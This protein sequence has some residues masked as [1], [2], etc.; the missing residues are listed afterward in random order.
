M[1]PSNMEF[2]GRSGQNATNTKLKGDS[3]R[4]APS[5]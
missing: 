5:L 3:Q 1:T 4:L 2:Y